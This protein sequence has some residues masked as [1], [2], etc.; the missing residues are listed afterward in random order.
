[1]TYISTLSE[2]FVEISKMAV[3]AGN[4]QLLYRGHAD[5]KFKAEPSVLRTRDLREREHEMLKQLLAEHPRQF[6]TDVSTF[7]LLARA[8]HYG[9]PTRL[10]DVTSNPLVA[11]YFA[12]QE[13][14]IQSS[15]RP[16]GEVV[17]LLPS[18]GRNRFFDSDTVSCLA[19]LT[20][21]D[22]QVKASIK[23]HLL[24]CYE[25]CTK[26]ASSAEEFQDMYVEKFNI[27]AGVRELSRL[28]EKDTRGASDLIHPDDL[29]NI[30]SVLP[31][32]LD[33]R[34]ASQSGAFM[35]FGL[36]SPESETIK[37]FFLERFNRKEVYVS[38][39]DK[40]R[41]LADLR[42]IGISEETLFPSLERTAKIIRSNSRML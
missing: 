36:F 41:V 15:R 2:F 27:H 6:E 26:E 17:V 22:F 20:F 5:R 7:E 29:T 10:L 24:E 25:Y 38:P 21:L 37:R 9:L 28:V 40:G 13:P 33:E 3:T 39:K 1:M 14:Q 18:H 34:I 11:L 42:S 16:A 31:R 8:Q 35:V 23:A 32:K 4:A 19:N 30:E 12:C